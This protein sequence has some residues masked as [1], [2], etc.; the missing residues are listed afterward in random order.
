MDV[1]DARIHDV[2]EW[3]LFDA[4]V[5]EETDAEFKRAVA[6]LAGHIQDCIHSHLE[7]LRPRAT[8]PATNTDGD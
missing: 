5:F 2:A 1:S 4:G 6:T 8:D 3:A 7:S